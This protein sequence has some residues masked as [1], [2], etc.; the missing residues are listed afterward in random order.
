VDDVTKLSQHVDCCLC[1]HM[2]VPGLQLTKHVTELVLHPI[3]SSSITSMQFLHHSTTEW[4]FEDSSGGPSGLKDCILY[5][6]GCF[7][8][9]SE[10]LN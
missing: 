4:P 9:Y 1:A 6:H 2:H 8:K 7:R 5:M 10:R 3:Y